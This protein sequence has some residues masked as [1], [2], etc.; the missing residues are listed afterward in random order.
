MTQSRF[1]KIALAAIAVP[2]LIMLFLPQAIWRG[3]A[4]IIEPISLLSGSLLALWVSSSYTKELKAAFLWLFAFLLVYAFAIVLFLSYHPLLLPW[5]STVLSERN[6]VI[7]VQTM[8]FVDYAMLFL[9]CVNILRAINLNRLSR[10]GWG[11]FAVSILL[12]AFLAVYPEIPAMR[13]IWHGATPDL[14]QMTMRALDAALIIV[15]TPVL[16]LYMQH[17]KS[18]GRQSLSF[19]VIVFGVVFFTLFDYLFDLLTGAL[20][21]L[22]S[23]GS[24]LAGAIPEAFFVYGYLLV[25]I[26]L[27]AHHQDDYWGYQAIDKALQSGELQLVGSPEDERG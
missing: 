18:Q 8:Q 26:G 6:I 27:Y 3:Y 17:R 15:L 10:G 11:I 1:F 5:L 13:N 4:D 16:W 24:S 2:A 22:F 9:F 20:P 21:K 19:T 25:V 12:S 7:I 14:S 23:P